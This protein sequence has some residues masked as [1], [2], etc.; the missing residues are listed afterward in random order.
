MV[1]DRLLRGRGERFG[2]ERSEAFLAV[3]GIAERAAL[4]I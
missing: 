4:P 2:R 3:F 1:N